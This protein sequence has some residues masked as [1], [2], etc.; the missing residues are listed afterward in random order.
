MAFLENWRKRRQ[1]APQE[2]AE[3]YLARIDGGGMNVGTGAGGAL[4]AAYYG[5]DAVDARMVMDQPIGK[6]QIAYAETIRLKYANGKKANDRRITENE[7]WYRMRQWR[8][9]EDG[10]K[11]QVEAITGWTFNVLANK[12]ADAMDNYPRPNILPREEGDMEEAKRLSSVIPVILEQNHFEETYSSVAMYKNKNG[13]GVYGVFWDPSAADGRGDI[14]IRKADLLNLFWE[15]GISNIQD[16][17]HLFHAYLCENERL[18]AE[19]PELE[20]KLSGNNGDIMQYAHDDTVDTSTKS[21]VVEWYYKKLVGRRTVL[22]YA[23]YCNG[24][25]LYATENADPETRERGLYDHGRYPFEFDTLYP[26]EGSPVGIGFVDLA[27]N[28]Q[29]YI[30]RIE[31]AI[32]ENTLQ[33]A[34]PRYFERIE[35]SINEAEFSDFT[36]SIIHVSGNLGEDSVRPVQAYPL[37]DAYLG[38]RDRKIEELKEVTGTRDISTGGTTSGV[39]AASAIA[40]MQEAGAK[41][42]RDANKSAYRT[43]WNIVND[44]IELIRQF[45]DLPRQFRITGAGD[46]YSFVK[47]DNGG[48]QPRAIKDEM[49]GEVAGYVT[50]VFDIKVTAEKQSPYSR[51][52]QNELA[53]QLLNL[54]IY[55]PAR[56]NQA[57][58]CLSMMDFDGKEDLVEKI[59][60]NGTLYTQLQATQA[61]VLR[62][63]QILD[64][65]QGGHEN[66]AAAQ[67]M[68]GGQTAAP[69]PAG[70]V[71]GES[72]G[73]H[74]GE[75]ASTTAKARA[76]VAESTAVR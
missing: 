17:P 15:P 76:R 20:G 69:L 39:T 41:L 36:K 29:E 53:L 7:K 55:E 48:L 33:G 42:S 6:D 5:G 32:L 11:T 58:M 56:S 46:E 25:V 43:Y 68:I 51:M 21:T 34:K 74:V 75:E 40:A 61:M 59:R 44:V 13:T 28:P 24:V 45:Y 63:A 4:P 10:K 72:P 47:Y 2:T 3:E 18:L 38:V 26:I 60:A 30:D 9:S 70:D 31:K 52:A 23:K 67:Q 65:L 62:L 14:A 66:V 37:S 64:T 19:Y 16:S 71:G 50:P 1:S 57:L 12:H 22:H 49:T 8:V 54:G 35:G 73:L 27:R